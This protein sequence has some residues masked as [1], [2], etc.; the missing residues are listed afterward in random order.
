MKKVT[1]KPREQRLEAALKNA[2]DWKAGKTKLRTWEIDA[3]GS[4]MMTYQSYEEYKQEKQAGEKLKS[5]RQEL[6]L[7]QKTF[8]FALRTSVRTLQG[9]EIG[10]SVPTPALVLAELFRD[11]QDVRRRLMA[12]AA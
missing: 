1:T 4:R 2:K 8:A 5:I 9:W 11:S 3:A 10:K 6:G 7:S 12:G